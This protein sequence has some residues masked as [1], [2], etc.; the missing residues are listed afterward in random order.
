M[1]N[2]STIDHELSA[3]SVYTDAFVSLSRNSWL[4]R[5]IALGLETVEAKD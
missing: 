1:P 2:K 3:E 5:P 4:W